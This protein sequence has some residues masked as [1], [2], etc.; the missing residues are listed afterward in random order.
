MSGLS[1]TEGASRAQ[2]V[3]PEAG[4]RDV[5]GKSDATLHGEE[6]PLDRS[7]ALAE[8]APSIPP[9]FIFWALGIVLVLSLGGLLGEHLFSAAGL[10][11]TTPT[12]APTP[13][14]TVRESPAPTPIASNDRSL[15]APLAAFMGITTPRSSPA[16]AFTLTSQTGQAVS[17]PVKPPRVVVLSFFDASC[18]DVCPVLASEVEQADAD[19]GPAASQVEFLTVNTDP[20]ALAQSAE[21]PV[22]T[23]TGLGK[24]ANWHMLTG[25]LATLNAVWKAYGVSISLEAKTGLEAHNDVLDFIDPRGNLRYRATPFAD[26]SATGAFSLAA[27]SISRWSQGIATY[28]ERLV[29]P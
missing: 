14:T 16:P 18:N 13:T 1:G 12:T 10:N 11:P 6:R 19:L 29:G 27:A 20:G 26:E 21:A 17:L 7:A 9:N 15:E 8:G 23:K 5:A 2:P 28:A 3:I 24:L 22:L 4:P 25:P